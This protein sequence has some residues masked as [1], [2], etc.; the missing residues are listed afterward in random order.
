MCLGG[1]HAHLAQILVVGF[2]LTHEI[3]LQQATCIASN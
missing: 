3:D 2:A 1:H